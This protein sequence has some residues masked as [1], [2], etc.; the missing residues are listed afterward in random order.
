MH[1]T[2][3]N[4]RSSHVYLVHWC[5]Y[6]IQG[7]F[8]N[9]SSDSGGGLYSST[10]GPI[11]FVAGH[12]KSGD[13]FRGFFVRG[14][15]VFKTNSSGSCRNGTGRATERG[16]VSAR[17]RETFRVCRSTRRLSRFREM[18]EKSRCGCRRLRSTRFD[19]LT[20]TLSVWTCAT[21]MGFPFLATYESLHKMRAFAKCR[22]E[23]CCA[24]YN[25]LRSFFNFQKK[26]V[27]GSPR[28]QVPATLASNVL[29]VTFVV[30][31]T[32]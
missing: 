5:V 12:L 27:F 32:S 9:G 19:G 21:R 6:T 25:V 13:S 31:K 28:S 29:P 23:K 7:L 10:H 22:K 30:Y 3:I 24:Q 26:K 17:V 11:K 18:T 4:I 15:A 8:K 20:T 14:C 1:R 16:F 2:P